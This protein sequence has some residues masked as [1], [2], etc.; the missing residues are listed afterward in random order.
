MRFLHLGCGSHKL[1]SP[2][3][4]YDRDVDISRKLPFEDCEAQ[5]IFAEHVIE[6]IPFKEGYAFLGE[7]YRVLTPGGVLRLSFPDI[8]RISNPL[9]I[10]LYSDA[11]WKDSK[12]RISTIEEVWKS[13]ATDWSHQSVWTH[14]MAILLL[15]SL[16]YYPITQLYFKSWHPE[17]C[18]IDGRHLSEGLSLA[19]AETTIIEATKL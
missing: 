5:F 12:K 10:E 8:T 3:E 7:C 11:L 9:I 19:R 16:M 1:P 18:G 14:D 4:N 17:L 2:W 13:V 6:H 15:R